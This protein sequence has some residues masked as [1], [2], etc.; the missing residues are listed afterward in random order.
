MRSQSGSVPSIFQSTLEVTDSRTTS[1]WAEGSRIDGSDG[2]T[3]APN[4]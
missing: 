4:A 3:K 1:R 2:V